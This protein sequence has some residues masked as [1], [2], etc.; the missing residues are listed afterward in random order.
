MVE[1]SP[2][3][4]QQNAFQWT[5][6]CKNRNCKRTFTYHKIDLNDPMQVV[7]DM[8]NNEPSKPKLKD[9]H[10]QRTCP[11]CSCSSFYQR[12][13]LRFQYKLGVEGDWRDREDPT[14]ALRVA[15]AVAS[16]RM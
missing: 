5:V 16:L 15:D 2:E 14:K 6:E 13:E 4:N 10:E 8:P 12:H 7:N 11:H 1:V 9:D 3:I